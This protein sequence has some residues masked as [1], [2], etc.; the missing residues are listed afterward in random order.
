M[1]FFLA[2][3]LSEHFQIKPQKIE[4]VLKLSAIKDY[5]GNS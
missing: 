3:F 2:E 5:G 4:T 1:Q